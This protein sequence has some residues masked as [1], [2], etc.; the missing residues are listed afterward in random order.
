MLLIHN[1]SLKRNVS[2]WDKDRN[3]FIGYV[4]YAVSDY[5]RT[6]EGKDRMAGD[7]ECFLAHGTHDE[8]KKG[9]IRIGRGRELSVEDLGGGKYFIKGLPEDSDMRAFEDGV[10]ARLDDKFSCYSREWEERYERIE[11]G[12]KERHKSQVVLAGEKKEKLRKI[13]ASAEV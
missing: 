6:R 7:A 4:L 11:A 8:V 9:F 12:K 10:Q 13:P 1:F 2:V 3:P 5:L